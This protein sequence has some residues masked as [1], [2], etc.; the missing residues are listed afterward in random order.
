MKSDM[1]KGSLEIMGMSVKQ[2]IVVGVLLVI[3][4]Q[5]FDNMDF[6]ADSAADNATDDVI[7]ATQDFIDW[8]PTIVVIIAAV[9]LLA[10]LKAIERG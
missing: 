2:L 3:A 7:S 10:Y 9:I 1:R 6:T 4:L 8:L 5:I